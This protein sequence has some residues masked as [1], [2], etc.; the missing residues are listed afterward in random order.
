VQNTAA[1]A[2]ITQKLGNAFEGVAQKQLNSMDTTGVRANGEHAQPNVSA[3]H[4]NTYQYFNF[5][6]EGIP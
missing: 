2:P 4:M 1:A 3:S 6:M 5:D